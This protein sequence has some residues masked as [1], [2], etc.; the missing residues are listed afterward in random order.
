MFRD[1]HEPLRCHTTTPDGHRAR[2]IANKPFVKDAHVH[3][4]DVAEM[5]LTVA[6]QTVHHFFV[7]RK[8]RVT[9]IIAVTQKRAFGAMLL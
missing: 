7:Y 8:A 3:A 5:Q 9:R 1:I 2:R 6:G 4:D